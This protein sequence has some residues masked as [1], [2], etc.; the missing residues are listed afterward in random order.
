M[1]LQWYQGRGCLGVVT[2]ED[3]FILNESVLNAKACGDTLVVQDGS[4]D[5][6]VYTYFPS[7][8]RLVDTGIAIRGLAVGRS[9]FVVWNGKLARVYR[10]DPQLQ[11]IDPFDLI[12]SVGTSMVIADSSFIVDE[13]LFVAEGPAIKILNFMGTQ[14]GTINFPESEGFPVHLDI[15]GKYLA[16]ITNKGFIKVFDVHTPTKP[17]VLCSATEFTSKKVV[18]EVTLKVRSIKVNSSGNLVAIVCDQVEGPQNIHF[19]DT[20][21]FIFDRNKGVFFN[22][23]FSQYKKFPVNIFWDESDDRLLLCEAHRFG[24]W[25]VDSNSQTRANSVIREEQKLQNNV[26][27]QDSRYS[28]EVYL[29]F[30]TTEQGI[31]MQDSLPSEDNFGAVIGLNVPRI[32]YRK[33]ASKKQAKPQNREDELD[34][35]VGNVLVKVMRDF[36]GMEN[37][38]D[39]I[40]AALLDFSFYLT[41]GRLDEAY[42]VVKE[43]DSAVIWENMAQ[44]CVKTKRLDVAEVC[45]GNMGHARGAA[46][47]RES[48]K[49]GSLEVSIGVLA[50]QLGLL[51]DAAKLFREGRRFDLLNKLYQA[52]GLWD[53]AIETAS[54]N[55]RIHLKSTHYHFARYLESIGKIDKAIEHYQYSEN[56]RT[57][58][59]RMLFHL[60]RVDELG[61]YVMQ[62]DDAQLLKWWAAYLES[63]DRLDKARKFYSKAKDYLSLVRIYCFKGDFQKAVEII[64]ETTDRASAYHFARQMENQGEF[65]EAIRFYAMSGC[66]NHSIRLAKAHNLDSEL[67]RFALKST[68]ALMIE[69]AQH[70]EAKNEIDKAVQL[71]H[72]GGDIPRALELC[73]RI[74]EDPKH[75]HAAVAFDMLNTIAQDLGVDSSPQTLARCADFLVQNRQYEKAV[76]LYVMAK[77][78]LAAIDMCLL[79][80]VVITDEMVKKLTPPE[81]LDLS[82]RREILKDLAKALKKQGAFTLASKKYTQAGDRVRAIKCLVRSGDTKAVIQF[83]TISRNSE[84]YTL[85]ANYLQQMNWRESMD[86]MRAIITFYTKAKAFIPLAGFYDSCAQVEIDE[87]R[88]YDK[89]ASALNEALKH[90][91]KDNSRTAIELAKAIQKRLL[92][93]EKYIEAKS[94]AKRDVSTMIAICEALLQDPT[95]D[96]AIRIGDCYA[97]LVEHY[98]RVGNMQDAYHYIREM[99]ERSIQVYSYIDPPVVDEILKTMGVTSQKKLP[100]QKDQFSTQNE[101]ER[102]SDQEEIADEEINEVSVII[103]FIMIVLFLR[104]IFN[105][106]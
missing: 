65:Q 95:V 11:R 48:K 38:T 100:T 81:T 51:D 28:R 35:S 45:L 22:F 57:E 2:E 58:V 60:G 20:H 4:R 106:K 67:M 90:L 24:D 41:L 46:A 26:G 42:R 66:Y 44:M 74:G 12:K 63:I 105:R 16:A 71:Y 3:T 34:G 98:Y 61:D 56:S 47:V 79:N 70:F 94:A 9:C 92:L 86:I 39:A 99:E 102:E 32:F 23:D 10:V 15:N 97:L 33:V 87:Y 75:P 43:I 50:V 37:I 104:I 62:S 53:K 55:D 7:E 73:F 30:A 83:A 85:A 5:L 54:V 76:D 17:K 82:E 25:R 91:G 36:V 78:Y 49:E 14:K 88:D 13:A 19:P 31:L 93:I 6:L 8:P 27:E 69:C 21:V 29:L 40:R 96:E 77:R 1:Q 64:M 84:I 101:T 80:R 52:A 68:P 89:A 103:I 72:K 59:P 18:N